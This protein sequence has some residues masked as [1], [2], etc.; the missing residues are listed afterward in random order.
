VLQLDC[1]DLGWGAIWLSDLS[2]RDF[3]KIAEANVKRSITALPDIPQT[4]CACTCVFF[5]FGGQY[6]GPHHRPSSTLK[7]DHP[8][9]CSRHDPR[10]HHPFEGAN[11]RHESRVGRYPD[12]RLPEG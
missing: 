7:G 9:S 10:T 12:V 1:P 8:A 4:A 2:T 11:P 5:F 3:V 6:E